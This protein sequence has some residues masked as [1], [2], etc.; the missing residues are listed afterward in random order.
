MLNNQD[1]CYLLITSA[2]LIEQCYNREKLNIG[3]GENEGSEG[4]RVD[5]RTDRGMDAQIAYFGYT[6]LS[7]G[8][9]N[10]DKLLMS[11]C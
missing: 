1:L 4:K 6:L 9:L 10:Y 5:G 7:K 3:R 8:R 11:Y 2:F